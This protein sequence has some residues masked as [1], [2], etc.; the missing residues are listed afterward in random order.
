MLHACAP[1]MTL[2]LLLE[3]VISVEEAWKMKT[4]FGSPWPSKVSAP[5]NPSGPLAL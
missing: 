2:T 5:L 3:A 4:A 1:L